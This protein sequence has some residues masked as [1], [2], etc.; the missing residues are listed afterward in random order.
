MNKSPNNIKNSAFSFMELAVVI[1]I[2]G[3]LVAAISQGGR[4]VEKAILSEAKV[5]TSSSPLHKLKSLELWLETTL[6]ESISEE[7]RYDYE[8]I[9]QW[10]S[11]HKTNIQKT[12]EMTGPNP[13]EERFYYYPNEAGRLPSIRIKSDGE[14]GSLKINDAYF[15]NGVEE[16]TF[17]VVAADDDIENIVD[18]PQFFTCKNNEAEDVMKLTLPHSTN[19]RITT[20][21]V[22]RDYYNRHVNGELLPTQHSITV[23]SDLDYCLIGSGGYVGNISEIILLSEKLDTYTLDK[24]HKYL[25]RKYDIK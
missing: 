8:A 25:L 23:G 15:L 3:I 2:I 12:I 19:H 5:T 4:L 20:Y 11:L 18:Q 13:E 10:N 24:V 7:Q 9:Y 22:A 17:I 6:D 14:D 21:T 1:I 16:F